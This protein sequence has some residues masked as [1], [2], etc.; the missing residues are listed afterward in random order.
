MKSHILQVA[1]S[2]SIL[3]S[4][5]GGNVHPAMAQGTSNISI[6]IV[7]NQDRVKAG[8]L[9][10]YTATMTNL[11]SDDAVFVDVDF[12]LPDQLSLVSLTCDKGISPDTPSCEYSTLTAGETVVST[13]VA[14][15]TPGMLTHDRKVIVAATVFFEVDC[16][17]DPNCT[18][19]QDLSNNS[20]SLNTTLIGKLAH[21]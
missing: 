8:Q 14:T 12:S 13:L 3:L 1:L 10:T 17:Y 4:L 11:G 16:S 19:D 6:T 9:I 20:A 2:I 7:T 21:P 18:F 5:L 15:P